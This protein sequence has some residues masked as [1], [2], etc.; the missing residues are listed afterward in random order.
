MMSMQKD[1]HDLQSLF[2]AEFDEAS[3][4]NHKPQKP[5]HNDVLGFLDAWS[6]LLLA[7][8]LSR[9][10]PDVITFAFW[11]RKGNLKKYEENF[12][13]RNSD[14]S[15]LGRGIVF[16][17]APS[18]V[19]INFAYSLVVGLLA[20]NANVV[21]VPSREFPQIDLICSSLD[22]LCNDRQ[23]EAFKAS[24]KLVRYERSNRKWTDFFSSIADVRI[25]WGGD[26]TIEDVKRSKIPPR[27]FDIA[28]ADRYSF[29]VLNADKLVVEPKI[30][31]LARGFYNDT[32]L[33]DQNACTAPH[34]VVW[35]GT[36]VNIQ[37]AK[38]K[39]WVALE[40][41]I[42]IEYNLEPIVAVDK[43]TAFCREAI[44]EEGIVREPAKS[45]GIIRIQL[46]KLPADV[47][48]LRGFGGYFNEYDTKDLNEIAPIVTRKFQTLSYYGVDK[49]EL[50]SFVVD[51]SL[52]GI[53]RIVPIGKTLDFDVMWDGWDLITSLSRI[54]G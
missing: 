52:V 46:D 18:N 25:I 10:Y 7:N 32:H 41:I 50:L 19:P 30:D 17:I 21:K 38:Q 31:D 3:L 45:N 15:R 39:F 22:K 36:K 5:Y 35:L 13:S 29:C 12:I 48:K 23:W 51:N 2:P 6:K 28:F 24:I 54:I 20:G 34:L 11:I 33:F 27:S 42:D 40:S 4:Q 49:D 1:V 26:N 9:A 37:L 53:D 47:T 8:P 14:N 44:H 16:H 43:L